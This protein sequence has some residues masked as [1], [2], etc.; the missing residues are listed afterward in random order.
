MTRSRPSRLWSGQDITGQFIF[1]VSIIVV[2]AALRV[3]SHPWRRF[4][5][6][7]L[8]GVELG[9]HASIGRGLRLT[10]RR[11]LVIGERCVFDSNVRLDARGGLSIGNDVNLSPGVQ[12]LTSEHDPS[13]PDF[14]GRHRPV[15]IGSRVWVATSAML[16]PGSDIG[17]G[18]IVAAGAVIRGAVEPLTIVAGNPAQTVGA[19]DES[20]QQALIP[21]RRFFG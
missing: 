6:R 10:V 1:D 13:A 18:A 14:A 20:A 8:A 11:C 17:D 2:N 3:P 5:L 21:Y 4:V 16:L 9:A 15:R 12:I 7:R 19:R